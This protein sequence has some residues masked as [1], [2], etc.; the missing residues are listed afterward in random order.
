M[1]CWCGN[2]NCPV[3]MKDVIAHQEIRKLKTYVRK[4]D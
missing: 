4:S 1:T 2:K 3:P